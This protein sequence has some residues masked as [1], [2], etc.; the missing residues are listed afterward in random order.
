MGYGEIFYRNTI[1][2]GVI[3]R[4]PHRPGDLCAG[5][6]VYPAHRLRIVVDIIPRC[7]LQS[8]C[9]RDRFG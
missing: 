9:D 2:S 5:G 4:D 6:A 1:A 8:E 3:P 7:L